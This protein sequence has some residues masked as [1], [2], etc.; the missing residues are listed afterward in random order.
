M[1]IRILDRYILANHIGPYFFS[2][3]II[4]FV[5][6][7][8]FI[9]NYL[10]KYT[11]KGIGVFTVL[12]FFALSLGHMFALIIPMAVMPATLM[13]FGQLAT[14]NE[15]TAMKSSGVSLYRMILPVVAATGMLTVAL[16]VYFNVLLPESN[17]R[18]MNLMLD[19]GRMKPTIQIKENMFSDALAGYTILVREKD[20]RTGAIE[21]VQIFELKG[22]VPRSI[23]ATSG[24]MSYLESESVL[25]FELDD[26]EIHEMPDP[27][28]IKTYRRT[29]FKHFTL[30][31]QDTERTLKRSER[32]HRG[33][34]E[35]TVG[36][37]RA[38]ILEYEGTSV[39]TR[40]RMNQVA[41]DH[42]VAVFSRVI[43]NMEAIAPGATPPPPR[44]DPNVIKAVPRTGSQSEQIL[45]ILE[46]QTYALD[47]NLRQISRYGVEI[48]KKYAIPFSCIIFTLLGAPLAI[49]SGKRG[50][51][52]SIGFS[53][54]LFLVYYVFL[55]G[56]EKLADRRLMEPWLSMW[57]GNI[58]FFVVALVLLRQTNR[59]FTVINWARLN[60][61]KRGRRADS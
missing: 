38:K 3:S 17:H 56:G 16:I 24:R 58:V 2:L 47:S 29:R 40:A 49:R 41:L 9:I 36:M 25:R 33:E 61:L 20:D 52:I 35:M 22:G 53:I 19:I 44:P 32:T 54:L 26:G 57:L 15:V 46:T 59:E 30:N 31:I 1:K 28:D 21:G 12:E 8:D 7:M 10:D 39:S 4:T 55:N 60:P 5:F 43:P 27:A 50:M 51:T 48:H 6:V 14:D 13:A 37:M 42:I 23:I 34:R 18:L 11:G 45:Q